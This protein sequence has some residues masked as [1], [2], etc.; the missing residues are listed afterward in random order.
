[1]WT[2][3]ASELGWGAEIEIGDQ[4]FINFGSYSAKDASSSSNR[5]E[6]MAVLRSLLYFRD[7]LQSS[8][9]QSL[10]IRTDSM[11]TVFNLQRQGASLTLLNEIRQI[12]SFL[13]QMDIRKRS[14]ICPGWKTDW[15]TR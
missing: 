1:L 6:T 12:F 14:R 13:T 7:L 4:S 2:T 15:R 9:V 10:A 5:R 8:N 3:D 11:V